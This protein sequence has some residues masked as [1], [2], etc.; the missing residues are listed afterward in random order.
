M[1]FCEGAMDYIHGGAINLCQ[2]CYVKRIEK[3]FAPMQENLRVQKAK[4]EETPCD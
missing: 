2:C 1:N 4:L 3:A